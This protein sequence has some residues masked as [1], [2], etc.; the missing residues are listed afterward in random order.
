MENSAK[1][2]KN[3]SDRLSIVF[4]ST[5]GFKDFNMA[6]RRL[7]DLLLNS[8]A[9]FKT[10]NASDPHLEEKLKLSLNIHGVALVAVDDA[11]VSKE[12]TRALMAETF[13]FMTNV[14]IKTCNEFSD[15][16]ERAKFTE[17]GVWGKSC[18]M[19]NTRILKATERKYFTCRETGT[20]HIKNPLVAK[21]S[22]AIWEHLLQL[23]PRLDPAH[24][25]MTT[26]CVSTDATR[27][28]VSEDGIKLSNK[29]K[30]SPTPLH[31][32]GLC[33]YDR[34][35]IILSK[36]E[37]PERLF[38]VPGS[39]SHEAQ[40][41]IS[42]ITGKTVVDG[43]NKLSTDHPELYALMHKYGVACDSSTHLQ[44]F[45]ASVWHFEGNTNHAHNVLFNETKKSV[46]FRCYIVVVALVPTPQAV[47]D[48][49]TF[50]FFREHGWAMDPFAKENKNNRRN[51]LFVN[52]KSNQASKV[53][54]DYAENRVEFKTLNETPIHIMKQYLR[55][56]VTP[57]RLQL[58][59]LTATDL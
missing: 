15:T 37:G 17:S 51:G 28:N 10:L 55:E 35:Q 47:V 24:W 11:A 8:T 14:T 41:I 48:M 19:P 31:Y 44:F 33:S 20:V 12:P 36:D 29:V 18:H 53:F 4:S 43:F 38:V 25:M 57:L 45:K 49:I 40:Q 23:Y 13:P 42:E 7:E 3:K 46:I 2:K 50:A 39:N 16:W 27:F 6:L 32:D 22:I 54:H 59:G 34:V 58:Y 26:T 1:I 21:N 30:Y 56:R 9:C 52:D 5:I